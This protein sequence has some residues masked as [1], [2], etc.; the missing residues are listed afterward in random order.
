MKSSEIDEHETVAEPPKTEQSQ[1]ENQVKDY[2]ENA[3]ICDSCG[4]KSSINSG[5]C[6]T[7]YSCGESK[8]G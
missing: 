3:I 6:F 1:Q 2:A 4:D 8:C 5:S 7:C